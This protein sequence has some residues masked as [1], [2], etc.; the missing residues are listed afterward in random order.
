VQA[1]AI[2]YREAV[3]GRSPGCGMDFACASPC[4]PWSGIAI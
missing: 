2:L 1:A 3:E 4:R